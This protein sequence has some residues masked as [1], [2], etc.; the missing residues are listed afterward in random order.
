M[1]NLASHKVQQLYTALTGDTVQKESWWSDF[2]DSAKRRNDI[3]HVG[4]K[5]TDAEATASLTVCDKFV[6]HVTK[7]ELPLKP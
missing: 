3:V 5:A 7:Y 6:T 4:R 2:K 1:D